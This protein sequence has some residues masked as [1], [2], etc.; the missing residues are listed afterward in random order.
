MNFS[1]YLLL[2]RKYWKVS[3]AHQNWAIFTFINAFS[4]RC[5]FTPTVIPHNYAITHKFV[6][7]QVTSN[8]IIKKETNETRFLK[9]LKI[10]LQQ[11]SMV[12]Q[13]VAMN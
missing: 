5:D 7:M 3:L 12:V 11:T 4:C 9:L 8:L 13:F 6:G 10:Y 2:L 1:Y